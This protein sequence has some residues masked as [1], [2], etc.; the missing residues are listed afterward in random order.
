MAKKSIKLI[1]LQKSFLEEEIKTNK[2]KINKVKENKKEN[3]K[4]PEFIKNKLTSFKFNSFKKSGQMP[5]ETNSY[6]RFRINIP[7][8]FEKFKVI[9][10]KKGYEGD[11]VVKGKLKNENRWEI[12]SYMINKKNINKYR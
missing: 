8:N 7:T 3:I 1:E 2:V 12:Q 5:K 10:Y 9:D 4:V 11:K 6:Y